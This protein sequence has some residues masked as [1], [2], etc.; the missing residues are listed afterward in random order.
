MCGVIGEM[1]GAGDRVEGQKVSQLG[2][3]EQVGRWGEEE[4]L[5]LDRNL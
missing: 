4:P 3:E 5:P 2:E 1:V